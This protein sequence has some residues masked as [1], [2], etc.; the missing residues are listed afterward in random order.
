MEL[1]KRNSTEVAEKGSVSLV[2][3]DIDHF[4]QINDTYGHQAGD[5]VLQAASD[6]MSAIMRPYDLVGRYGGEGSSRSRAT[7][8]RRGESTKIV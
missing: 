4:K 1:L 8:M 6:K 2:F 7:R 5:A 3:I